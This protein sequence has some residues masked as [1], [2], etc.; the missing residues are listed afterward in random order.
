MGSYSIPFRRYMEIKNKYEN[1]HKSSNKRIFSNYHENILNLILVI[2]GYSSKEYEDYLFIREKYDRLN[3][4]HGSLARINLEEKGRTLDNVYVTGNFSEKLL[5]EF[6]N[7]IDMLNEKIENIL[8]IFDK[9][10][11]IYDI[12]RLSPGEYKFIDEKTVFYADKSYKRV[13]KIKKLPEYRLSVI[14]YTFNAHQYKLNENEY[15]IDVRDMNALW[16]EFV[17]ELPKVIREN[18]IGIESLI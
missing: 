15:I 5:E 8:K 17:A 4:Y 3:G 12:M 16:K 7:L 13:F 11:I 10:D 6:V 14:I 9:D 1:F 2:F 18:I